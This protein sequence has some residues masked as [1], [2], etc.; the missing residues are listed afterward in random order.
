MGMREDSQEE[1]KCLGEAEPPSVWF[2]R[3]SFRTVILNLTARYPHKGGTEA[4]PMTGQNG[5][6]LIRSSLR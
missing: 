3:A 2:Q 1:E 4:V 5:C 6:R